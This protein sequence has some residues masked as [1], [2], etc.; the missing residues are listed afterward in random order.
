MCW[1]VTSVKEGLARQLADALLQVQSG[2]SVSVQ[3]MQ[4]KH[5]QVLERH[6]KE[7]AARMGIE[8]Q[9]TTI[10]AECTDLA[11]ALSK[12]EQ[13]RGQTLE[14]LNKFRA[15]ARV[16]EEH[17]LRQLES[18]NAKTAGRAQPD[19]TAETFATPKPANPRT[20]QW[21]GTTAPPM[22][23]APLPVRVKTEISSEVRTWLRK[24]ALVAYGTALVDA[25]FDDIHTIASLTD[26]ELHDLASHLQMPPGHRKK[27]QLSVA[28]LR[29]SRKTVLQPSGLV[30]ATPTHGPSPLL[31]AP[32]G[33]AETPLQRAKR[34]HGQA[35]T[36][37]T[38]AEKSA[39]LSATMESR[40]DAI[41]RMAQ[42]KLLEKESKLKQDEANLRKAKLRQDAL[43]ESELEELDKLKK[44]LEA[45]LRSAASSPGPQIR[46][47]HATPKATD[48]SRQEGVKMVSALLRSVDGHPDVQVEDVVRYFDSLQMPARRWVA[49]LQSK[50]RA[51]E[52]EAF[53]G[54]L[55]AVAQSDKPKSA[56]SAEQNDIHEANAT[57]ERQVHGD[58]KK[59][60]TRRA[61]PAPPTTSGAEAESIHK[62]T[63][64]ATEQDSGSEP[65]WEG[66]VELQSS[67]ASA[68][69]A[70]DDTASKSLLAASPFQTLRTR[71]RIKQQ[72]AGGVLAA[73]LIAGQQLYEVKQS[74]ILKPG[75]PRN[76]VLTVGSQAATL[77]QS[78]K[79]MKPL[80]S[81]QLQ[82]IKMSFRHDEQSFTFR[83]R[84]Q[85]RVTLSNPVL[86]GIE[87]NCDCFLMRD[88]AQGGRELIFNSEKTVQIEAE[89]NARLDEHYRI[90]QDSVSAW[91]Q[92][93]GVSDPGMTQA[94]I[95]VLKKKTRESSSWNG[96]LYQMSEKD[97][98]YFLTETEAASR[99]Q[100]EDDTP[101]SDEEDEAASDI[102]TPD[103]TELQTAP[104]KLF[105]FRDKL[106]QNFIEA[107]S[108]AAKAKVT[109]L[110]NI[111][112]DE[113]DSDSDAEQGG[114]NVPA[115]KAELDAL[116]DGA[117]RCLTRQFHVDMYYL[118]CI[119]TNA[120]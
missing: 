114:P 103:P 100:L 119:L 102:E 88:F 44:Q 111:A 96:M 36:R 116:S 55:T 20:K 89:I 34:A 97:I 117:C 52:L 118:P 74:H 45:Q 54:S 3:L 4:E 19:E 51:G 109:I 87:Q 78:V 21:H 8:Q 22:A 98:S 73:T 2:G 110:A 6:Q 57:D 68:T 30:G 66:D 67:E 65:E 83:L 86:P 13:L 32:E 104:Q 42:E 14:R 62:A 58:S 82:Q 61:Q 25:G 46:V 112:G 105:G 70:A 35:W 10:R 108:L 5:D 69:P 24:T 113:S 64:Q 27:L 120:D 76:V 93:Q 101:L 59:K 115:Q 40:E 16:K 95:R 63:E 106:P 7:C 47:S 38:S 81:Y 77:I 49:A 56:D 31:D 37:L 9:L 17:L 91:L 41:V 80:E 48:S 1:E 71:S 43:R 33:Q 85:V 28:F 75:V 60:G 99:M 92:Q 26:D 18:V 90:A 12:E 79:T 29:E 11:A 15:T 72:A 39:A 23:T 107:R 53:L 84:N 94:A 50:Q